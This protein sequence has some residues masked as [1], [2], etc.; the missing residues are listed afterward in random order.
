M[1]LTHEV[2]KVVFAEEL[3]SKWV[4]NEMKRISTYICEYLVR[5]VSVSNE[6]NEFSDDVVDEEAYT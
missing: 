3:F 5:K 6:E 4:I 1:L 2:N